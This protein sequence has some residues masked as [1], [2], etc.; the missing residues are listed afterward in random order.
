MKKLSKIFAVAL[1]LVMVLS[2]LPLGASAA[3]DT[4]TLDFTGLTGVGTEI[5]DDALSVFQ[6]AASTTG[7][8]AVTL[9]KVYDGNGTGGAFPNTAGMLKLG[10]SKV[11]G[12]MELTFD[13]KV[14][15]VEITCHDW[16]T[17]SD[18][19]PTNSNTVA[20]NGSAAQLAPYTTDATMGVL[21]FDLATASENVSI[22][23]DNTGSSC[24][25]VFIS[26]I[27]VTFEGD[28]TQNPPAGG[29]DQNPPAGGDEDGPAAGGD[30]SAI[31]AVT[32]VVTMAAV[33]LFVLVIGKKKFF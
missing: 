28:N 18:N 3:S 22:V 20:V 26:K 9:T 16:Y 19:Y 13:K 27:V 6:G 2:M 24:G 21:T 31:I 30:T 4:L 7:L 15:K 17:K 33:A 29:D 23:L 25:R 1:C 8:T 11:D 32:T 14:A 12:A 10:T 5:T